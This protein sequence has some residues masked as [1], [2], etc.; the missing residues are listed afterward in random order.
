MHRNNN[1]LSHG[2]Y[3]FGPEMRLK[4]TGK[5]KRRENK[6]QNHNEPPSRGDAIRSPIVTKFSAVKHLTDITTLVNYDFTKFTAVPELYVM[7]LYVCGTFDGGHCKSTFR[8][9]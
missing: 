1:R 7:A 6:S 8:P 9:I 2:P 4:E 3:K 5:K